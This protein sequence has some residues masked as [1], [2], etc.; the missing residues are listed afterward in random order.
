MCHCPV[1]S[2]AD[3]TKIDCFAEAKILVGWQQLKN[4][5]PYF[6][7]L[8]EIIDLT[9]TECL[10]SLFVSAFANFWAI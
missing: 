2:E 9:I 8:R 1:Y 4:E 7:Y 10:A 3:L 6:K 5:V